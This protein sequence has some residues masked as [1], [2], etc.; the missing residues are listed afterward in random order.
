MR[1]KRITRAIQ[2]VARANVGASHRKAI[3]ASFALLFWNEPGFNPGV[4]NAAC[5]EAIR[6]AGGLNAEA[7]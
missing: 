4:F 7:N 3:Q 2:I 1:N 5:D 6:M